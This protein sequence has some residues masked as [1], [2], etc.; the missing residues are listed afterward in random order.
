M[1]E[2]SLYLQIESLHQGLWKER[3][4]GLEYYPPLDLARHEYTTQPHRERLFWTY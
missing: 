1:L 4:A 2:L 3:L